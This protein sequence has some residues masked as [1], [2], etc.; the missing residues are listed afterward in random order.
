MKKP[1]ILN[2]ELENSVTEQEED[3]FKS[4]LDITDL[5]AEQITGGAMS[6]CDTY[7]PQ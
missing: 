7:A 5:D 2:P 3:R 6:I 4:K 1:D